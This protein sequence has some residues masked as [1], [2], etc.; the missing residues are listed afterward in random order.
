MRDE[1]VWM[2]L[3]TYT[4][5]RPGTEKPDVWWCERVKP[6]GGKP[7]VYLVRDR[8]AKITGRGNSVATALTNCQKLVRNARRNAKPV[9]FG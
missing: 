6:T 2:K 8:V 3:P 5:T 4:R 9:T 7:G 1:Y